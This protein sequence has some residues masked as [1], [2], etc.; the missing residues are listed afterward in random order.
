MKKLVC[1][2][3]LTFCFAAGFLEVSGQRMAAKNEGAADTFWAKFQAAVAKQN[4][5]AVA[6]STKIPLSMPYGVRSIKSREELKRRFGRIFDPETRKCFA[7]SR[8]SFDEGRKD[9]FS[10]SCGEAMMYWFE[11]VKGQYRFS[12]VDNV[13]E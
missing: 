6:S 12:A 8:P 2:F 13:N 10:I 5:E 1:F 3:L 9:R 11:L 7:T 4:I